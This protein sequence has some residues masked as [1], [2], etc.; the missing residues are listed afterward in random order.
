MR[1]QFLNGE[2]LILKKYQSFFLY[3]CDCH[4][5][6][7]LYPSKDV[8]ITIYRDDYLTR[9]AR[10]KLKKGGDMIS[11]KCKPTKKKKVTKKKV[12]K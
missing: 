3:C 12:K 6:H 8:K 5:C 2:S 9:K 10:K 4:L 7:L 1:K 11:C